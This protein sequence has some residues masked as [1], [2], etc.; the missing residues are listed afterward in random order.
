[1][2]TLEDFTNFYN[3]AL[4][5]DLKVLEQERRKIVT[6][7]IYVMVAIL[8]ILGVCLLIS[9]TNLQ[10]K[11]PFVFIVTIIS[12][13]AYAAIYYFMT[14]GHV[15]R[16]KSL[17]IQRIVHFIDENLNYDADECIDKSTFMLSKIFTTKPNQ[18]QGDDLVWGKTGAT[19]IK[20]SE[21]KAE[22]ESGSGKNRRRYTIFKGLFFIGDFNLFCRS[23]DLSNDVVGSSFDL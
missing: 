11:T 5:A 2:K 17:V 14:R 4:L 7:L 15:A 23:N 16:F 12:I 3:T 19:E 13:L 18:Y 22:H 6:K 9:M 8:C 10:V 20:F 1:M 21:I